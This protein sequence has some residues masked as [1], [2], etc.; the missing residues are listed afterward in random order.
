MK[1]FLLV[2]V[3]LIVIAAAGA[4]IY[5]ASIDWNQHKDKIAA[6]FQELTGKKIVFAGPVSFRILPSPYLSA[7]LV[8]I[9]GSQDVREK[10]LVEMDRLVADL[11]LVPLL[12]GEFDVKR[13]VLDKPQI[14]FEFRADGR[15]NWQS[16]MT[17]EQRRNMENANVK[18]NSVSLRDA[19]VTF[20]DLEQGIDVRL[21]SLN[22]EIVAQSLTGPYRIEGNYVKDN[23]PE[24][25]A[26]SLGQLSD[27][28][29]TSL[30][31]VFTDPGS[32]SYVRFDGSFQLANKVLNGNVI[33]ES[34][35]LREFARANVKSVDFKP[36]Y[37]YPLALTFDLNANTQQLNLAN[38]V[39]KYGETQGAG[40]VQIPLNDGLSRDDASIKPRVNVAFN[41]TDFNLDPLVYTVASF[42]Q[43]YKNGEKSYRPNWPFDV[44]ADFKSVRTVYNG[45]PVKNFEA[46][47][48]VIDNTVTLNNMTATLPGDTDIKVK[49]NLSG[50]EDEPF[51][52]FDFSFNSRDFLKTLNW[53][54]IN[55]DVS[56]ASTYRNAVGN[57][58]LSGTF[59]KIQVSPFSVTVD[60]SSLSGEAGLKLGARNDIMLIVDADMI[61]FDNYIRPLPAE[62]KAKNWAGRMKYRFAKLGIINDFD[63][64]LQA[65]IDL[66]IYESMPFERVDF[67]ANLLDGKLDV[68]NLSI[69][70]VA[71]AQLEM[72]GRLQGF[73]GTPQYENLKYTVKTKDVAA[74]MNKLEFKA[75]DLNYAKLKNF[76][77]RGIMTGNLEHFATKTIADLEKLNIN[78]GGQVKNENGG[79]L[80]SGDLE[81]KHPDFVEMLHDFNMTYSPQAYSLG[82]FDF[83]GK[84]DGRAEAFKIN[85][86][87]FNIGFNTFNGE[88]SYSKPQN[89]PEITAELDINKLEIERF[90]NENA[91]SFQ[92]VVLAPEDNTPA[93][94]LRRPIWSKNKINYDFYKKFNLN[95]RFTVQ[96]L[97]YRNHGFRD[98]SFEAVLTD[99]SAEVRN[100]KSLYKN[101]NLE[102]G[103]K[104]QMSDEPA[105]EGNVKL[106]GADTGLFGLGGKVYALNKGRADLSAGFKGQAVSEDAFVSSLTGDLQFVL[107]NPTVKG[108]NLQAV[109]EDIV[110]REDTEGLAAMVSENLSS[111][112]SSF[113]RA[114][115]KISVRNGAFSF[116]DAKVAGEGVD[117]SIYG[118][119][120]L[121]SWDMNM[122]FNVKYDEPKYL[123]GYSFALKGPMNAPL[124]DVNVS[125]LFDLYKSRQDKEKADI[126]AAEE[127]E[128]QRLQMLADSEK[129]VS[130]D[131]IQ[132]IRNNLEK[133]L[134][135]RM[136]AFFDIEN[137]NRYQLLKQ[138]LAGEAAKLARNAA[139]AGSPEIDDALIAKMKEANQRAAAQLETIRQKAENIRL[140]D[141]KE[142][143]KDVYAQVVESYN[144][145]K[146]LIF[147]YSAAKDAL[148]SRL[149]AVIT[150]YKP[151]EDEKLTGWTNFIEDKAAGFENQNKEL[152]D[153]FGKMQKSSDAAEIE[154]YNQELSYLQEALASDLKAMEE[155]I[156]NFKSYSDQKAAEEEQKYKDFLREQEVKKKVEENTG[157]IS[158][159][160]TGQTMT[161]VR[162]IEEIEKAE[163]LT[164]KEAV[165]VL[166]FS[167]PRQP[168]RAEEEKSNVNVVKKG[169]IK[170]K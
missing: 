134:D 20:E 8:K 90:L 36:E 67:K 29:S 147:G 136:K 162:D 75:P 125:A 7:S 11:A 53:M 44:L 76:E 63:M 64:Q 94:F 93:E 133:G 121:P 49:G 97:S 9:Y 160:K 16:D 142:H 74:L 150:D 92:A 60:K 22:G 163:E 72:S 62:E 38:V 146:Q 169:R 5:V 86:A 117:I 56:V 114:E 99:G 18:L 131:M 35:K 128:K 43:E 42:I 69:G 151:D 104:L 14:N 107:T 46:S 124:V 12:K 37:D 98:A 158:I 54:N 70:S 84:F 15:L 19:V 10:P 95:G 159:K 51:Y 139:L 100:F 48:D 40:T 34:E 112:A 156:G 120:S 96:D 166:D 61:N 115:G 82:L 148:N 109:Y 45:Q 24:G 110:K 88:I 27:S 154:L 28:F 102:A 140:Q 118:D 66:G 153:A 144:K 3:G 65:K 129:K 165:K 132:D 91:V 1:K 123:P 55:P 68:E 2:I 39:V 152:L 6:Q 145:S 116:A 141:A 31:M 33:I 149:A 71:N 59:N 119:G 170:A 111:G 23:R 164:T 130:D 168:Q 89:K 81:L 17:P 73:G 161:V 13:M 58:K 122:V 106:N 25:F 155:S 77:A 137:A 103:M 83:R 113:T 47:F 138:D 32:E 80:F 4:G 108:W 41:F 135:A 78:Y 87:A 101:G 127:A 85:P 21:D 57:A 126:R 50:Y 167:K 26:I 157:S 30:N 52:N 143:G 79:W 105:V